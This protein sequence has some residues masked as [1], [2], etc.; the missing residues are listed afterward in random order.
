MPL[1]RRA[2]DWG[3][4][5]T[6]GL[7]L[8]MLDA[9]STL[10]LMGL[11][12]EFHEVRRWAAE[13]L[14]FD[15][16]Y[17]ISAFES[18]IRM[19]GALVSAYELSGEKHPELVA[20]ARQLADILL[21]AYNTSSGIPHATVNLRTRAHANPPWT[22]GSSVLSE[23]GTVQLELRTLSLHTGML[24]REGSAVV[25]WGTTEEQ[26]HGGHITSLLCCAR[27]GEGLLPA[28]E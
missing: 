18:T 5:A 28:W 27:G 25:V 12:D 23:F 9:V 22:G 26:R 11:E 10:W 4:G 15:Q 3:K 2:R 21:V 1:S 6:K 20:K 13:E 8:T 14:D 24:P 17:D 7:G 19:V 16:D